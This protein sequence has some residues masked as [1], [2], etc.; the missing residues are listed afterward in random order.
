MFGFTS[1]RSARTRKPARKA[2]FRPRIE[3]LEARE[4]LSASSL[5]IHAV[6][7]NFNSGNSAVFF[8]GQRD[9][10]LYEHDSTHGTRALTGPHAAA[11]FAPKGVQ[12]FS[13]GQD[14]NGV[15][16]VFAK[17]TNGAFLEFW[18]GSWHNL[19]APQSVESFAAVNG[20]RAYA[21]LHDRSLWEVDLTRP[22]NPWH[23]ISGGPVQSLDAVT[24]RNNLDSVFVLN[25]N[26]TFGQFHQT[27]PASFSFTYTQLAG[28]LHLRNFSLPVVTSFSAGTDVNGNADVYATFFFGQLEKNVG[29]T[30]TVVAPA[31]TAKQYSAT[32]NGQVWFIASNSGLSKFDAFGTRHDVDTRP[33]FTSI[34]AAH[35]NDVYTVLKNGSIWERTGGGVWHE[36]AGP[37]FNVFP[38]VP[39]N[40]ILAL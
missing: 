31:G 28:T 1:T 9:H 20:D 19:H 4:V 35:S 25:G 17:A 5:A 10:V 30:W 40:P 8:M 23:K 33:I 38:I 11:N 24:D 22:F 15:A 39:I 7:D 14:V 13:A 26:G 34:S 12:S 29:G 18:E 3:T 27:S 37:T 6:A 21:I 16:N 2:T 36:I 32:D